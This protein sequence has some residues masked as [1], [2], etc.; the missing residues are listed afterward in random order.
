VEISQKLP[1]NCPVMTAVDRV[2]SHESGGLIWG[3]FA[4]G[5]HF[6]S[7]IEKKAPKCR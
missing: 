4:K 7:Q 2:Q 1:A 6:G 3:F 5:P